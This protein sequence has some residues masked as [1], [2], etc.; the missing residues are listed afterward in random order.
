V[1]IV[2]L[3]PVVYF[4]DLFSVGVIVDRRGERACVVRKFIRT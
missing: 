1:F 4:C 2:S 3:S